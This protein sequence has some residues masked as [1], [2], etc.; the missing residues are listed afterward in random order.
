MAAFAPAANSL[1]R[2]ACSKRKHF[3]QAKSEEGYFVAQAGQSA[4][5]LIGRRRMFSL[6]LSN[7]IGPANL[8]PAVDDHGLVQREAIDQ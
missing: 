8:Y 4:G 3:G 1:S 5:S 2:S 6:P 7:L